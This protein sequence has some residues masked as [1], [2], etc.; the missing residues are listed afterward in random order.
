MEDVRLV[1]GGQLVT[2]K[3]LLL[4]NSLVFLSLPNADLV[5]D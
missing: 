3:I 5:S 2:L 4:S 1:V